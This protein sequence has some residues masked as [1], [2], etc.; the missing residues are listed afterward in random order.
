MRSVFSIRRLSF[1]VVLAMSGCVAETPPDSEHKYWEKSVDVRLQGYLVNVLELSE[2]D[3]DDRTLRQLG[4]TEAKLDQLVAW[5]KTEFQLELDARELNADTPYA[6]LLDYLEIYEQVRATYDWELGWSVWKSEISGSSTALQLKADADLGAIASALNR[7]FRGRRPNFVE[8]TAETIRTGTVK[9]VTVFV[10]AQGAPAPHGGQAEHE[11]CAVDGCS[12]T[13]LYLCEV[14]PT[15][16]PPQ[17]LPRFP[18]A[19]ETCSPT[20][21]CT[22]GF[23]VEG[24]CNPQ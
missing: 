2:V 16:G 4:A 12:Y 14:P 21:P 5:I 24:V 6:S 1:V 13:D 23:C 20:R 7:A 15:G 19:G 22:L 18:G 9:M 17:C 10:F 11:G 3:G 8:F